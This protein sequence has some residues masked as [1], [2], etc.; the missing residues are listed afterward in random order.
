MSSHGSLKQTNFYPKHFSIQRKNLLQLPPKNQFF[1]Q[2]N[3]YTDLKKPPIFHLKKNFLYLPKNNQ[4]SKWKRNLIFAWK[5]VII[6][7]GKI[8]LIFSRKAISQRKRFLILVWKTYFLEWKKCL[9]IK[10]LSRKSCLFWICFTP[11]ATLFTVK[12]FSHPVIFFSILNQSLL[13]I[14]K[15]IF[16]SLT[17][18]VYFFFSFSP[19][20]RLWYLSIPVAVFLC[21]LCNL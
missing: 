6:F 11:Y 12:R 3:C 7:V 5:K 16:I 13:F 9:T 20:K 8:F 15:D 17:P 10:L 21:F 2:K 4:F 19:L 1:K 18:I 14:F